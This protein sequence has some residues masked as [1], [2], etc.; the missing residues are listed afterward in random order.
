[1]IVYNKPGAKGSFC[2][3]RTD[4]EL[5]KVPLYLLILMQ[6]ESAP[7][8]V[9]MNV[10]KYKLEKYFGEYELL[11]GVFTTEKTA[12]ELHADLAK[13]PPL[14]LPDAIE[15]RSGIFYDLPRE[16]GAVSGDKS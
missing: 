14:E 5:R 6:R 16:A 7:S 8:C 2:I 11:F 9:Y 1:M 3:S 4:N 10:F 15:D 13:L 12:L